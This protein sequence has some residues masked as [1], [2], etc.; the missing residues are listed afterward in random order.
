[1]SLEQV[2][3]RLF[4]PPQ[5]EGSPETDAASISLGGVPLE[6]P[7]ALDDALE[8]I[9]GSAEDPYTGYPAGEDYTYLGEVHESVPRPTGTFGEESWSEAE[10]KKLLSRATIELLDVMLRDRYGPQWWTLEPE[11][12]LEDLAELGFI[13]DPLGVTRFRAMR[14]VCIPPLGYCSFYTDP[15]SFNFLAATFAGRVVDALSDFIPAPFE[16]CLAMHLMAQVRPGFYDPAVRGVIAAC[17][18]ENG[19]WCLSSYLTL[20]QPKV[21]R[22]AQ[23][24]GAPVDAERVERVQLRAAELLSDPTALDQD[25]APLDEDEVQALRAIDLDQRMTLAIRRG[26]RQVDRFLERRGRYHGNET[27]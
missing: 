18:W 8:E 22:I 6:V 12:V 7:L 19:L 11:P 14:A 9:V 16:H 2:R 4:G 3:Q 15:R 13:L 26:G 23:A 1:M 27:P 20:A 24:V 5:V 21:Y 17:A 25:I 10:R